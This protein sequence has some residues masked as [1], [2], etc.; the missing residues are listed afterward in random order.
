MIRRQARD[1]NEPAKFS[2]PE[3]L[4]LHWSE[5]LIEAFALGMF[6]ISASV[7]TTLLDYPGAL[8]NRAIGSA[9]LRLGMIGIS[10]GA[11]AVALIY[12]PW[13]K[14][15][16][17]HMNPAVTLAFLSLE[18]IAPANA[19]L[20]IVAQFAGG[21]AGVLLSRL[22][23]GGPFAGPPVDYIVTVPGPSGAALAFAAE[24]AI[25][26]VMMFAI[27]MLS[28]Q[29]RWSRY[30]GVVAGLLISSYVFFESP[31]SGFSMNPARTFASALPAHDYR[32]LWIYFTAPVIAMWLAARAFHVLTPWSER[33]HHLPKVVPTQ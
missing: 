7:V 8:L 12:S 13:G 17:A 1:L 19:M 5:F 25:S 27:L 3:A 2:L 24:F 23:L 30:T 9:A 20:Y 18:R 29:A 10:M 11:T 21:Y 4:A 26:F 16:G 33:L 28:N 14:L 31:L 6:M 22:L 32:G 15:S